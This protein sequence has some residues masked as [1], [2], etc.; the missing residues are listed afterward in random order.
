MLHAMK[1]DKISVKCKK[2]QRT[3]RVTVNISLASLHGA[4]E[5]MYSLHIFQFCQMTVS[6]MI[7]FTSIPN[8][9][10]IIPNWGIFVLY[11]YCRDNLPKQEKKKIM[12]KDLKVN[13]NVYVPQVT[14][15]FTIQRISKLSWAK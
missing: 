15:R 3:E 7:V 10:L 14:L 13:G 2:I 8:F 1:R 9:N 4:Q 5:T 6:I 11:R 12:T